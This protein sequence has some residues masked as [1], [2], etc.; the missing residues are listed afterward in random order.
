MLEAMERQEVAKLD[1]AAQVRA[2]LLAPLEHQGLE[3]FDVEWAGGLLRV[4]VD[5]PGGVD[6]DA[7]GV[8]SATVSDVLDGADPDPVPGHY[9]LEVS[10]PGLE[11]PLRTP[12]H[13]RRF[14]GTT[15]SVKTTAD[16]EGE[17]RFTGALEA[18]D[19]DGVTVAGRRLS[20]PQIEWART[21]FVW[22]PA[23]KP[24]SRHTGK[25]RRRAAAPPEVP[26][27]STPPAGDER[28]ATA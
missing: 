24:G 18:A 6:L 7:L 5:R 10:S 21:V 22:G 4:S 14:V 1:P 23:P 26:G 25:R 28:K 2:L 9:V 17:R 15:V 27:A 19:D 12:A 16:V 20:Y 8:A 11:R 13:W 3:L